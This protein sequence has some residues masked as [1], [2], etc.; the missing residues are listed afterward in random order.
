MEEHEIINV[1]KLANSHQL[2]Y[3]QRKV[4]YLRNDIEMLEVQ[5]TKCSNHILTLNRIIDEFQQTLNNS[6]K[7]SQSNASWYSVDISYE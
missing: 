5:K 3:L 6:S 7:F 1:L 2:E 4:E